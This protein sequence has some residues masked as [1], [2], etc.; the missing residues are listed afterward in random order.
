M[1]KACPL[2]KNSDLTTLEK[3]IIQV[4]SEEKIKSVRELAESV[5]EKNVASENNIIQAILT[6]REKGLIKLEDKPKADKI[7]AWRRIVLFLIGGLTTLVI[8]IVPENFYPFNYIRTILGL[9][10]V[11]FIPGYAFSLVFLNQGISKEKA[12]EEIRLIEKIAISIGISIAL[13]FLMGLILYYS[14]W[15]LTTET[16]VVS[17]F[18]L[19]TGLI[20][21]EFAKGNKAINF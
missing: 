7:K 8:F 11:F 19:I 5:K 6:L 9:L 3:T 16:I 20:A 17:I 21:V 1:F 15:G 2:A 10:F 4:M 18:V 12:S 14:P 13:V